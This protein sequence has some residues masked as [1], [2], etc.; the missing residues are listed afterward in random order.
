MTSKRKCDDRD[1][2]KSQEA[3]EGSQETTNNLPPFVT[4][5]IERV[6][7][8]RDKGKEEGPRPKKKKREHVPC[9][10]LLLRK[11]TSV[12]KLSIGWTIEKHTVWEG[13]RQKEI[14]RVASDFAKQVTGAPTST[15]PHWTD[16]LPLPADATSLDCNLPITKAAF[17][18]VTLSDAAIM[19]NV[20]R[21]VVDKLRSN[22]RKY[23][24]LI[25]VGAGNKTYEKPRGLIRA[26]E[27]LV[28]E[29]A[30]DGTQYEVA[31]PVREGEPP[32]GATYAKPF[33]M[34]LKEPSDGLRRT[35][36]NAKVVAFR[37]NGEGFAFMA[38]NITPAEKPWVICNFKGGP[39]TRAADKMARALKAIGEQI[40]SSTGLRML[41]N[42]ILRDE[43]VGN[44]AEERIQVAIAG[45]SLS[46]IE[47]LDTNGRDDPVWQL[48]GRPLT[49][50]EKKH[51]E[52]LR[53]LRQIKFF[54][55]TTTELVQERMQVSCVW[56]KSETHT[57]PFC[58]LPKVKDWLGP[59]PPLDNLVPEPRDTKS[60]KEGKRGPKKGRKDKGKAKGKK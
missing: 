11:G 5:S 56:C 39:V 55:N 27:E 33:A 57:N 4:S 34:I 19:G 9:Q 28:N 26:T 36:L 31:A 46:F 7:S 49:T 8:R 44:S 17:P 13:E 3:A 59:I 1:S 41:A 52:W 15:N 2:Q 50:V 45:L 32:Y 6:A 38:S 29:V 60:S 58:P 20:R 47:R 35:L 42:G 23:M 16:V 43:G 48:H 12:T 51:R 40:I 22:K 54:I 37:Y 10:P 30:N 18:N 21:E 25:P 53:A 24:A 14:V